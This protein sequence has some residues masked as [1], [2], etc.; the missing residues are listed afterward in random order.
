MV[1]VKTF[2]ELAPIKMA[3][4]RDSSN[5]GLRD[6]DFWRELMADGVDLIN[7]DKLPELRQFFESDRHEDRL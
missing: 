7:T 1:A 4:E 5:S 6:P 2:L 3:E